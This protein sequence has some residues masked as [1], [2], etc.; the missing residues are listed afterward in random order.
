MGFHEYIL[1]LIGMIENIDKN[2]MLVLKSEK[3]IQRRDFLF[4]LYCNSRLIQKIIENGNEINREHITLYCAD[5]IDK[6]YLR[7]GLSQEEVNTILPYIIGKNPSN[8]EFILLDFIKRYLL[9]N[10]SILYKLDLNS[11]NEMRSSKLDSIKN[12]VDPDSLLLIENYIKTVFVKLNPRLK[13]KIFSNIV[14]IYNENQ[15][16]D[17]TTFILYISV[18][19]SC[20]DGPEELGVRIMN[21]Y[22]Q[23]MR[24]AMNYYPGLFL[25]STIKTLYR[26]G[27]VQ[28]IISQLLN[29]NISKMLIYVIRNIQSDIPMNILILNKYA[30]FKII[31]SSKF[32]PFL[33]IESIVILLNR[34]LK[35][36]GTTQY[37]IIYELTSEPTILIYL[38]VPFS[39]NVGR[40]NFK[41]ITDLLFAKIMFNDI[42]RVDKMIKLFNFNSKSLFFNNT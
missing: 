29:E 1:D 18:V 24:Q 33:F 39:E 36:I 21:N 12:D 34:Y 42:K 6:T 25:S 11:A 4:R 27:S 14:S 28:Q 31:Y 15:M 41:G 19:K 17:T 35:S 23:Y 9:E 10:E 40:I 7:F 26:E 16:N 3:R 13:A 38:R 22:K 37:D 5:L 2:P 32:N 30:P 8:F 20:K